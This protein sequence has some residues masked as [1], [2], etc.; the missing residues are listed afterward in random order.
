MQVTPIK[1]SNFILSPKVL[2]ANQ[3]LISYFPF[4]TEP[5][6]CNRVVE[7]IIPMF[8][9]Y[10]TCFG[11]HTAHHQELRNCNYSLWFYI[12]LLW[13]RAL[14]WLRHPWTSTQNYIRKIW[15]EEV[16]GRPRCMCKVNTVLKLWWLCEW[17]LLWQK[18]KSGAGFLWAFWFH[19]MRG[20]LSAAGQLFVS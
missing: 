20:I 8:L 19:K 10:S 13:L 14:R 12:R 17:N 18:I 4:I 7:F 6:R 9:N 1:L 16:V 5:T 2:K 11:W 15:C 3:M